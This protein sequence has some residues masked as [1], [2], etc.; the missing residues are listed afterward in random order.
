[1]YS[2][3]SI[4]EKAKS[5]HHG[6]MVF[7]RKVGRAQVMIHK[8]SDEYVVYIDDDKLD[9]YPSQEEAEKNAKEFVKQYKG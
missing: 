2:F 4:R 3:R 7:N 9:G 5:S 1:M 6:D 8:E